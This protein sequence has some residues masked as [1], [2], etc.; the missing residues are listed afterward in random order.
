MDYTDFSRILIQELRRE[1][2]W[3]LFACLLSLSGVVGGLLKTNNAKKAS[4]NSKGICLFLATALFVFA[5]ITTAIDAV[6]LN[7][8][9]E[10]KQYIEARGTYSFDATGAEKGTRRSTPVVHIKI[11]GTALVLQ[12]PNEWNKVDFPEG[13]YTG[14]VWYAKES[15]I[16]LKFVP[17]N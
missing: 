14:T 2:T 17:D 12:L 5:T 7:H 11:D 8:D 1:T 6:A 16:I 4:R 3:Y 10:N 9:I 13:Y 15:K